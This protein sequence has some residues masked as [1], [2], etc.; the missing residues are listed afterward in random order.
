[1]KWYLSFK[2]IQIRMFHVYLH[3]L[4]NTIVPYITYREIRHDQIQVYTIT[5]HDDLWNYFFSLY[6]ICLIWLLI[7][8]LTIEIRNFI[9]SRIARKKKKFCSVNTCTQSFSTFAYFYVYWITT[10]IL[11]LTPWCC[12]LSLNRWFIRTI[13]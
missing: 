5:R 13:L 8:I 2:R 12:F 7:H 6:S 1:M 10:T 11:K 9:W 4:H 3:L